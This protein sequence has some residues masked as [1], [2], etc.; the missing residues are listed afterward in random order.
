MLIAEPWDTNS[1][2][3]REIS[4]MYWKEGRLVEFGSVSLRGEG[5]VWA[6]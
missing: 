3:M 4:E 5:R 6:A 1:S 2:E